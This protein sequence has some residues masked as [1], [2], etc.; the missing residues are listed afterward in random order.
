MVGRVLD[1]RYRIIDKLGQGGFAETY[2]AE[3][4]RVMNRQVVVKHLKPSSNNPDLLREAKQ[5][6]AQEAEVLAS[7]GREHPQIPDMLAYFEENQEFYLVQEFV[8]GKTLSEEIATTE[9][10]TE[11]EAVKILREVLLVLKFVHENQVIHRDIKPSNLMR[12]SK[13]GKIV[14]IDFGA[15]K[16]LSAMVINTEGQASVTRIIGSPG[17]M[18]IEQQ[19][20]RPRFSSDIYALGVTIIQALTRKSLEQIKLDA[21]TSELDWHEGVQ[22]NPKLVAILDKMVRFNFTD[23]Y[24][25]VEQVL[26]ELDKAFPP[27]PKSPG[28]LDLVK[29][30][31]IYTIPAILLLVAGTLLIPKFLPSSDNKTDF[32]QQ[33]NQFIELKRYDEAVIAFNRA[34]DKEPKSIDALN[35][36]GKAL[37]KDQKYRDAIEAFEQATTIDPKS[38]VAWLGKGEAL[39]AIENNT[40]AS[41]AF[42]EALAIQP[43]SF[44]A[45]NQY[46]FT[47]LSLENYSEALTVYQKALKIKQDD[48]QT[49]LYQGIALGKLERYEDALASFEKVLKIEPNDAK[50]LLGKGLALNGLKRYQP[51]IASFN[52]AIESQRDLTEAWFGKGKTLQTLGQHEAALVDFKTAKDLAPRNPEIW[53]AMGESLL[54]LGR[55]QEAVVAFEEAVELKP[56]FQ[57]ARDNEI[58]ARQKLR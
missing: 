21:N 54:E 32:L 30:S 51:A 20:G 24:Q 8:Q 46:G 34:L 37:L 2:L 33:G 42:K 57:K 56:D 17:Y 18:A 16:Q 31:Y 44:E 6:F 40:A 29:S 3:D 50:A 28:W 4:I 35:G 43:E 52:Q 7:L 45:L 47:L 13:D 55:Y 14:L 27:S 38:F 39:K 11:A 48:P 5:L 26:A 41:Q 22:V 12:R 23:R 19:S 36:K 25:S 49:W 53:N 15:V 1:G 10:L 9:K 58:L